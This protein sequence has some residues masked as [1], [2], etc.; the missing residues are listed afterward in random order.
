[1]SKKIITRFG[2]V[3]PMADKMTRALG[4]RVAPTTIQYWWTQGYIPIRRQPDV[5]KAAKFH[6]VQ[7]RTAEFAFTGNAA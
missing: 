1:M 7:I 5:I 4:R 3:Y 6:G 2:G